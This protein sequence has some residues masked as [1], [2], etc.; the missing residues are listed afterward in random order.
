MRFPLS[1]GGFGSG[2]GGGAMNTRLVGL[3]V[4]ALVGAAAFYKYALYNG[5]HRRTGDTSESWDHE[6]K[7]TM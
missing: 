2:G 7:L 4:T 6:H 5:K 3:G 1:S